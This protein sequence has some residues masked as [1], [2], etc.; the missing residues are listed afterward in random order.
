[1]L[2]A[3]RDAIHQNEVDLGMRHADGFDDVLYGR[4]AVEAVVELALAALCRQKIIEFLVEAE[5]RRVA[6]G[7][8]FA[9]GCGVGHPARCAAG[10]KA[11]FPS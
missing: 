7:A 9:G 4:R 6:P 5:P 3:D 11:S 10:A 8:S 1:M 2:G